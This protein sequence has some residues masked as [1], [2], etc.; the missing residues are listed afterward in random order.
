MTPYALVR[1]ATQGGGPVFL[2][3]AEVFPTVTDFDALASVQF[4]TVQEAH[5]SADDQRRPNQARPLKYP[6]VQWPLI[7]LFLKLPAA[8]AAA[9]YCFDSAGLWQAYDVKRGQEASTRGP[10]G[11]LRSVLCLLCFYAALLICRVH[12][13]VQEAQTVQWSPCPAHN[14]Q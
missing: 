10:E 14:I 5:L 8:S 9:E 13:K 6:P 3:L 7:F 4:A 11:P 2:M 12:K 1:G